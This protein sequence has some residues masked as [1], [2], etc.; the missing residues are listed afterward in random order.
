MDVIFFTTHI[1]PEVI[2]SLITKYNVYPINGFR[3]MNVSGKLS[4]SA[5]PAFI[6][7]L[8]ATR[9]SSGK[10]SQAL[11]TLSTRFEQNYISNNTQETL[12]EIDEYTPKLNATQWYY[13]FS[14]ANTLV[15]LTPK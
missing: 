4:N 10:F 2:N 13:D 1:D 12:T 5:I 8:N 14:H 9:I 7:T 11:E 15:I 6:E 3:A